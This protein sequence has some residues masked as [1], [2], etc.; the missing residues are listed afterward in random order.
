M[1][2]SY[3][4]GPAPVEMASYQSPGQGPPGPGY[5]AAFLEP[6]SR[7]A[8]YAAPRLRVTGK[9]QP[10]SL[11]DEFFTA[12]PEEMDTSASAPAAIV[13]ME[14]QNTAPK[15]PIED[16]KPKKAPK[17]KATPKAKAA[18]KKKKGTKSSLRRALRAYLLLRQ[19]VHLL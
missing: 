15:R 12:P 3:A 16:A 18:S 1:I 4:A 8:P 13:P 14:E 9:S 2:P 10:S 11:R 7:P 19:V 17:A 5:D 6:R